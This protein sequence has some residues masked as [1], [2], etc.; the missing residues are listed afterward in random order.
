MS[1]GCTLRVPRTFFERT[2]HPSTPGVSQPNCLGFV[3]FVFN[4]SALFFAQ[5]VDQ[6]GERVED[7]PLP[8]YENTTVAAPSRA[9]WKSS[10][11]ADV[12]WPPR[13]DP[14]RHLLP[15]LA[16]T[17]LRSSR[18][19][20]LSHIQEL[21]HS[22]STPSDVSGSVH[23]A[24]CSA[25]VCLY[26]SVQGRT[27]S[28]SVGGSL[29]AATCGFNLPAGRMRIDFGEP[30]GSLFCHKDGLLMEMGG[31]SL[32]KIPFPLNKFKKIY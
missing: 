9:G 23:P 29:L 28:G 24:A 20:S 13:I 7:A 1:S 11:R 30:I 22:N 25:F 27:L 12:A 17:L 26:V 31:Y 5:P 21:R 8:G 4:F 18:P 6:T 2:A 14:D 19:T 15:T 32:L 10:A 3:G 16:Y